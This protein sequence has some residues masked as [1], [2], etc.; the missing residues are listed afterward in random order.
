MACIGNQNE[1][2][3]KIQKKVKSPFNPVLGEDGGSA[4][5]YLDR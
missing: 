5:S 1:P 2:T 4:K 3:T